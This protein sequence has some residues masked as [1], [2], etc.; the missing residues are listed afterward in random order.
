[1]VTTLKLVEDSTLDE[2]RKQH[3]DLAVYASGYERRASYLAK[4]L[5]PAQIDRT[6]VLGF[7]Q[8]S[9]DPQRVENDRLFLERWTDTIVRISSDDDG[10][11]YDALRDFEW[12][13][14]KANI[15][16]DYSSMSRLW[17]AG[18]LNWVRHSTASPTVN[19]WFSYA[20]PTYAKIVRPLSVI[21]R[22]LAIPGMEGRSMPFAQSVAIFGLGFDEY[23]TLAVL[24]RLEPDVVYSFFAGPGATP[25][26]TSN[27]KR[28]NSELIKFSNATVEIPLRSVRFAF[29]R[30]AEV[31]H[32]VIH[33]TKH[34]NHLWLMLVSPRRRDVDS[35]PL[36]LR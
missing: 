25:A 2:I 4:Q 6:L 3:F 20:I 12:P 17:Y 28:L 15:L 9:D 23:V 11:I 21:N 8:E 19:L 14:S 13:S 29:T 27:A 35:H 30:I 1:M 22:I 32:L 10:P 24:D 7:E 18:I 26:Y 36:S 33:T 31:V 16:I 5:E 34:P